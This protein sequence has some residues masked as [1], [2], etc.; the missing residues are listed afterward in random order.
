MNL[1]LIGPPGSGKGTQAKYIVDKYNYFQFSTGDLLREE[2]KKKTKIGEEI[3][4]KIDKGHFVDDEIVNTLLKNIIKNKKNRN[5][6]IFDGYPRNLSQA[7]NLELFLKSDGQTLGS[8]IFL[9]LTKEN[10]SKRISGRYTCD[11]CNTILNEFTDEKEFNSHSCEK[12]YLKKRTDDSIETVL[13]RYDTY[14][15]QTKPV[16][17]Y[18]TSKPIFNEIDG[19]LKIDEIARKIDEIVNV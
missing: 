1:I 11:K 9:N 17:D 4:M 5:K 13:K 6:I 10:V 7:K 15:E 12:K 14:M 3:S 2:I 19:S 18:Y 8:I 16:L